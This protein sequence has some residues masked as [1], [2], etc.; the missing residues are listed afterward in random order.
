MD[1]HDIIV[2]KELQA[3]GAHEG[4]CAYNNIDSTILVALTSA[5]QMLELPVRDLS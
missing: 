2:W 1:N 3:V 4:M 5:S